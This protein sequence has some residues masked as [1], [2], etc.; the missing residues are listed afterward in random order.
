MDML[1]EAAMEPEG[2]EE[3]ATTRRLQQLQEKTNKLVHKACIFTISDFVEDRVRVRCLNVVA[4]S[5]IYIYF[6]LAL[7]QTPP[8]PEPQV[9]AVR[10]ATTPAVSW[11]SGEL[12]DGLKNL[13]EGLGSITNRSQRIFVV[14]DAGG[15]MEGVE[16]EVRITDFVANGPLPC[17]KMEMN[18]MA[19]TVEARRL[20]TVC[21]YELSESS[22]GVTDQMGIAVLVNFSISGPGGLYTLKPQ[23]AG[24]DA[25]QDSAMLMS[26]PVASI[27]VVN[28]SLA[29][30]PNVPAPRTI[31]VGEAFAWQPRLLVRDMQGLPVPGRKIVAFANPDPTWPM[32]GANAK[33]P[34]YNRRGQK[35]VELSCPDS[36]LSDV[37]GIARFTCLGVESSNVDHVNIVFADSALVFY[38]WN[39]GSYSPRSNYPAI[40]QH[41]SYSTYIVSRVKRV[42]VTTPFDPQ[43]AV[44]VTGEDG[45]PVAGVACYAMVSMEMGGR[46]PNWFRRRGGARTKELLDAVATTDA[47]GIAQFEQLRWSVEGNVI[48]PTIWKNWG[49]SSSTFSVSFNCDGVNQDSHAWDNT[50]GSQVEVLPI[51]Q[52]IRIQRIIRDSAEFARY[53]RTG[54]A[55]GSDTFLAVVRVV[56]SK[57]NGIPGKTVD[58]L[59]EEGMHAWNVVTELNV[60]LIEQ[61]NDFGFAM[62]AFQIF[63]G[64]AGLDFLAGSIIFRV[65]FIV[66]NVISP[67]TPHMKARTAGGATK[68][69][70]CQMVEPLIYEFYS[71]SNSESFRVQNYPMTVT[72][73]DV[74]HSTIR[75]KSLTSCVTFPSVSTPNTSSA[76]LSGCNVTYKQPWH[77]EIAQTQSKDDEVQQ[78]DDDERR[79]RK[80]VF[81]RAPFEKIHRR[82]REK[83]L[84]SIRRLQS[85][86]GSMVVT[87]QSL[88]STVLDKWGKA[89]FEPPML[90]V[91]I[92][93]TVPLPTLREYNEQPS[94]FAFSAIM[95]GPSGDH[96]VMI[97]VD[98]T[99]P[100]GETQKCFSK[101]IPIRVQN[102]I[103]DIEVIGDGGPGALYEHEIE[104]GGYVD[105]DL[106]WVLDP[107]FVNASDLSSI[108]SCIHLDDYYYT[109]CALTYL[110]VN[111]PYSHHTEL[112]LR[113]ESLQS[114][115]ASEYHSISPV[116]K[117]AT[118]NANGFDPASG[119]THLRFQMLQRGIYGNFGI[120]FSGFGVKSRIFTWRVKP[121]PG[122]RIEVVQAPMFI[123]TPAIAGNLFDVQ[124]RVTVSSDA[125]PVNGFI[126]TFELLPDPGARFEQL[127]FVDPL[128]SA[129]PW[130]YSHPSGKAYL[131][132]NGNSLGAAEDG[133]AYFYAMG[134]PDGSGCVRFRF[135]GEGVS[136]SVV[137]SFFAAPIC[138]EHSFDFHIV[139]QPP[140]SWPLD[141][142]LQDFGSITVEFTPRNGFPVPYLL[143]R[144]GVLYVRLLVTSEGGKDVT[145]DQTSFELSK[146]MLGDAVCVFY[147]ARE[148]TGRCSDLELVS[149]FPAIVVRFSFLTVKWIRRVSLPGKIKLRVADLSG[150]DLWSE[151]WPLPADF[152]DLNSDSKYLACYIN[153]GLSREMMQRPMT[154]EIS[155][156]TTPSKYEIT[157][158][159]PINIRVGV[160]FLVRVKVSTASGGP[161]ENVRLRVGIRSLSLTTPRR[162][163]P[164]LLQLLALQGNSI[165]VLTE[166]NVA[167]DPSTTVRVSDSEGMV[168]FPLTVVKGGSGTYLLHFEPDAPDAK[169]V[170]ETSAFKVE[171]AM[172][173]TVVSNFSEIDIPEFGQVVSV[174]KLPQFCVTA[175]GS[176][177][178]LF[179]G[180]SGA[181]VGD[182]GQLSMTLRLKAVPTEKESAAARLVRDAKMDLQ[183]RASESANAM[184][185]RFSETTNV[186]LRQAVNRLIESHNSKARGMFAGL[187]EAFAEA[188]Y[189]TPAKL[190]Q[191]GDPAL[192]ENIGEFVE[193]ADLG[194]TQIASLA[195][196]LGIDPMTLD[197]SESLSQFT[198]LLMS[199]GWNLRPAHEIAIQGEWD[200]EVN[201][202]T[203]LHE[204]KYEVIKEVNFT[205]KEGMRY[206]FEISIQGVQ[207]TGKPFSVK[208]TKADHVDVAFNWFM[209][210]SAAFV[211]VILLTSNVTKHHWRWLVLAFLCVIGLVIALPW[212]TLHQEA[213]F[214][215]WQW[216][217]LGNLILVF[218]AL[219]WAIATRSKCSTFAEKRSAIFEEYS[220]RKVAQLLQLGA[221]SHRSPGSA[222][223]QGCLGGFN[224][225]DAFFFPSAFLLANLLSFL[226]F[227]Y[228]LFQSIQVLNGLQEMLQKVLNTALDGSISLASSINTAY[229]RAT[230]ADLPDGATSFMY[231]QIQVMRDWF[232]KFIDSIVLGF[233][234]GICVAAFVTVV[235]LIGGFAH[236]KTSVML[237]RR[238]KLNFQYSDASLV[239]ANAFIGIYISSTIV[240]YILIVGFV[241][242]VAFPFTFELTW[243]VIWNSLLAVL[244]VFV[245]PNVLVATCMKI[246]KKC[247]FGRTF[248]K[249]RAGASIF[250]FLITFLALPG[251]VANAAMRFALGLVGL[252]VM[253]PITYGPNTPELMN[254]FAMLD[255]SYRSY[256]SLVLLYATH[257][258]PIVIVAAQRFLAI[259]ASREKFSEEKKHWTSNRSMLILILIRFPQV[260]K[261]R[262]HVL[263]EERKLK[264]MRKGQKGT[265][266]A[267]VEIMVEDAPRKPEE[268]WIASAFEDVIQRR[269]EISRKIEMMKQYR[270]ILSGLEPG[271]PAYQETAQMLRELC[272]ATNN[273]IVKGKEEEDED[274]F[275]A[276]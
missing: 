250:H 16:V 86:D 104:A 251:G 252:L 210:A 176:A 180:T 33:T 30:L 236:F 147:Y 133:L 267:E 157:V 41:Y 89:R 142:E 276:L 273:G 233:S 274:V 239:A 82:L 260:R 205:F 234:A 34:D 76:A 194:G 232:Q 8:V 182:I 258:N 66:D 178:N 28:D 44:T 38:P 37:N 268:P 57:G 121:P 254:Q 141:R 243:H 191:R 98:T 202:L 167:L 3:E 123:T 270:S 161:V 109:P 32:T 103:G 248:V 88:Y 220:R 24:V 219:V 23:A 186:D 153:A 159:P 69:E 91:G 187:S 130:M 80:Q 110:I 213:L 168:S 164:A 87:I 67:L 257:N 189:K 225:E 84:T 241:T 184:A 20:E 125:G 235:A 127:S 51:A 179:N 65:R 74:F 72:S 42:Q 265:N 47:N 101:L 190:L 68:P 9:K 227:I 201:D 50:S 71:L 245:V 154:A 198:D 36:E 145:I 256:M 275:V 93:P 114:A 166:E 207:A 105:I 111:A 193:D 18:A 27:E 48:D 263:V 56:D 77:K 197:A 253:L 177:V 40:I 70:V 226:S 85:A 217:A 259:K 45:E 39:D 52:E 200:L 175:V 25:R 174:P 122:L 75:L 136:T 15:P 148:V 49:V 112:G 271:T 60:K 143:E 131:D 31:K 92:L 115:L 255:M 195:E 1:E 249:S 116:Q 237:A 128:Y 160:L 261:Y 173:I 192:E 83:T 4:V 238:G 21:K 106:R 209:S 94:H 269:E 90:R 221:A 240:S 58:V 272:N 129:L 155:A 113:G 53:A 35:V 107:A 223:L 59:P 230:G 102:V 203:D 12:G 100:D 162:T 96:W 117:S 214:G 79:L 118:T 211:G 222:R 262:K 64:P 10:F 73:G 63:T 152:W 169:I 54:A 172:N 165:G 14:D 171:N 126:A 208:S 158:P 22:K 11:L 196:A 55:D 61:T 135:I 199:A 138:I 149:T 264:E 120:Q 206:A 2:E 29:E 62:V 246:F 188:C 7:L 216:V 244:L 13:Y 81:P 139:S 218:I 134:L 151:G 156:E 163:S 46:N 212:M 19:S 229:F 247:L 204:C 6:V 140:L 224:S 119:M 132:A 17:S 124:P 95:D 137:P 5:L 43:P 99:K 181:H 108:P 146:H 231:V 144:I 26:T 266:P 185:A 183:R 150:S 242:L 170:L 228:I 215:A 97:R 78:Q